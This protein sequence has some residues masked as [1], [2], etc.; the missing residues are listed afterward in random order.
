MFQLVDDWENRCNC[1]VAYKK[2]FLHENSHHNE[3]IVCQLI[4]LKLSFS[5]VLLCLY[6]ALVAAQNDGRYRPSS[7]AGGN[8][9]K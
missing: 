2:R 6:V 4:M 7:S 8:D 5:L 1:V 9:G 3:V